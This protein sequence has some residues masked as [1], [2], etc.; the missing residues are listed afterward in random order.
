MCCRTDR[1]EKKS[2]IRSN[3]QWLIFSPYS[4]K[5]IE[6]SA[7]WCRIGLCEYR[8]TIN[9]KVYKVILIK[10]RKDVETITPDEKN[11]FNEIKK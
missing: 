4:P 9:L 6:F 5:F 2:E 7:V 10:N 8:F 3:G 1:K 11:K